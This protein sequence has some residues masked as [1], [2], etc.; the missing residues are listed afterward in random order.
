LGAI[1]NSTNKN[2][3]SFLNNSPVEM[4]YSKASGGYY[5]V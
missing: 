1:K 3:K 5:H 4:M 2:M